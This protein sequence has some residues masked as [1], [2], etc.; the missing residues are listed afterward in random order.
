M[1]E[2]YETNAST[3]PADDR[4]VDRSL[5]DRLPVPGDVARWFQQSDQL[6][7]CGQLDRRHWPK[8]GF[9]PG[10][11]GQLESLI[12]ELKAAVQEFA[13]FDGWKL[14]AV[15]ARRHPQPDGGPWDHLLRKIDETVELALQV[16]TDVLVHRPQV[17][18]ESPLQAQSVLALE[19]HE[20]LLGGGWD[21]S[22]FR[23]VCIG[24]RP[25]PS[26]PCRDGH[27]KPLTK[28]PRFYACWR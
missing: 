28:S 1:R 23:G 13:A 27:R 5:P 3:R 19:I 9:T 25:C 26:G 17:R 16:Q 4:Y 15:D 11:I 22:G 6:A 7:E 12:A 8:V 14:A 20:H 18:E 24:K 21:G 2:L 10:H